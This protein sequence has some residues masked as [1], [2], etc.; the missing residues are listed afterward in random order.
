MSERVLKEIIS[1]LGYINKIGLGYLT[2]NRKVSTLSGGEFQRI[3]LATSLGSSL[4]GSLYVLDEP[5]VGL[6]PYNTSKLIE[7]LTSLKDVGNTVIVVEHDDEVIRSSDFLV[8][9][10]PGAGR[11]GGEIMY[12]GD[13]NKISK[14]TQGPTS[15]FIF[16]K[17][18]KYFPQVRKLN[19]FLQIKNA[20]ENN[21]KNI[22]VKI[23][24]GG[25]VV[26]TGVSG[27]G[28][29]TLIKKVLFPA[30]AKILESKFEREGAYDTIRGDVE[31]IKNIEIVDQNP[32]GRSSRSNPVTYTKAYDAIR[33]LYSKESA[34]IGEN[35]APADFSFN[36]EG[37]RCEECLGEGIKKIEMQFMA[38]IFLEC[39][40]CNGKRFKE[41]ILEVKIKGKNIYDV[42]DMTI[43][44]SLKFFE[45]SKT[46]INKLRPLND[47][48]LGYLKLGQSS[49]TL[50]GGEAQRL[51]LAS[52]LIQDNKVSKNNSLFIFDEPTSGLHNMDIENFMKSV[53]DLIARDNSVIIIEHN[54]ELIKQADWIIDMGPGG[55]ENGGT[56]CFEG[57]PTEL[58]NTNNNKT[59]KYLRKM[60]V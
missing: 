1:R 29:S 5:T 24:L 6:H 31:E 33:K 9:I 53:N 32:I 49:S 60:F 22:D 19:K 13:T 18:K 36:V 56:I 35:L 8:D 14:K 2:L 47:V 28:K 12:C 17:T 25:L 34:D 7:I 45:N 48:G 43:E 23:P 50:S 58:V 26:V 16:N 59:G 39:D 37:G 20:R 40:S 42:L 57:E 38:D 46:I 27:S 54:T 15:Q 4:V 3:K 55:G 21:L 11:N 52:Y 30:I 51:K 44:D 41:K 10:G